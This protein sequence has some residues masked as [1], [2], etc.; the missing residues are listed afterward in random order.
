VDSVVLD[1]AL[2]TSFLETHRPHFR[3]SV[4][5]GEAQ[6]RI[7]VCSIVVTNYGRSRGE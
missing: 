3:V 2:W 5:P 4:L 6:F 7:R 1:L